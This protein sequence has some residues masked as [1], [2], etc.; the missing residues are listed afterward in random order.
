MRAT[1]STRRRSFGLKLAAISALLMLASSIP[2]AALA[3]TPSWAMDVTPLPAKVSP[4]AVA[5]YRVVIRNTGN[6]NISQVFLT[7]ALQTNA[8]PPVL[9]DPAAIL[10]IAYVATSQGSCDAVDTIE[11]IDPVFLDCTLGAIR[12]KKSATVTVAYQTSVDWSRLR[13]IFEANTTGVAGDNPGSSHGDVLQGVGLTEFGDTGGNFGGRF[14]LGP[15]LN[16]S[17]DVALTASNRQSTKVNAPK[18]TIGVSVA[19]GDQTTPVVC[20]VA[21]WSETSEIHVDQGAFFGSGFKVEIGIYKDLSQTVHGVWHEFDAPRVVGGVTVT[22]ESIVTKCPK[23]GIP[24]SN[25]IPCFT[26]V[27]TGGGNILVTVWLKENGKIGNF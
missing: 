6:S 11:P 2:S 13:V 18:S 8:D 10:P 19:D 23:N 9:A 1:H 27:S 25:Q 5:G 7:T 21:C 15:D 16:V 26:S 20:P 22:G 12:A 24:T 17:D 4:G 14:L 3:A